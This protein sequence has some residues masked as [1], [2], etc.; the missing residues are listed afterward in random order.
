M[1]S[2][3]AILIEEAQRDRAKLQAQAA[4]MLEAGAKAQ[5]VPGLTADEQKAFDLIAG[6]G[7][8]VEKV[9][10]SIKNYRAAEALEA[11]AAQ[12]VKPVIVNEQGQPVAKVGA[13]RWE[14]GTFFAAM[15]HALY[16]SGGNTHAAAEYARANLGDNLMA[17]AFA[18]PKGAIQAGIERM[19]TEATVAPGSTTEVGGGVELV[20]LNAFAGEFRELL[21]P[22][23]VLG[24][25]PGVRP[26]TFGQ[27]GSLKIR[28]QSS[29]V[30]GAWVGEGAP[31][32]VNRIGFDSISMAPKKAG[33][34]VVESNE[35]LERADPAMLALVRDDLVLGCANTLDLRFLT[36]TAVS[37][38]EPPGILNGGG[39]S[40]G[41]GTSTLADFDA[42]I[43]ACM[44]AFHTA[45]IP[46]GGWCWIMSTTGRLNLQF[47]RDGNGN[48]PY[49]AEADAGMLLGFP[50]IE[51]Q[52]ATANRLILL[53]GG[54][55]LRSDAMMPTISLSQEAT[56]SMRDDPGADI[57]AAGAS[58]AQNMFQTDSTAVRL[59][60]IDDW[61]K[62]YSAA[63]YYR[64]NVGWC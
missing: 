48:A 17:W 5:P 31:I 49:K 52:N 4:A 34:I 55:V 58:P 26:V 47:I 11:A 60:L 42:D 14:K 30:G 27:A 10:Q 61:N 18:Q 44:A 20:A 33:V 25:V 51:T 2:A 39:T 28:G 54:Q 3:F 16:V 46:P 41:A 59:I 56:I 43:K 13:K 40:A 15:A 32:P 6:P 12:P 19:L 37:A 38:T 9:D 57:S 62:R 35:L 22:L 24:R 7:G 21:R 50:I 36:T 64:T 8:L 63:A 53:A 45:K 29:G 1:K 23:S